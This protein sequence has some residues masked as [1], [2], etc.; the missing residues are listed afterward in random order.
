METQVK[1][2]DYLFSNGNFSSDV[3]AYPQPIGVVKAVDPIRI[4][5]LFQGIGDWA[6][7]NS[8]PQVGWYAFEGKKFSSNPKEFPGL[9]GIV[10]GF[11]GDDVIIFAVGDAAKKINQAPAGEEYMRF[12]KESANEVNRSLARL[13]K[14]MPELF[15]EEE[16]S[17]VRSSL[18]P[19][20]WSTLDKW[21]KV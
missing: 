11:N 8:T 21:G 20:D 4:A 9:L 1:V 3:N 6:E 16:L 12:F 13:Q 17:D 19:D 2:G 10:S 7:K 18:S 5:W 14:E 15:P